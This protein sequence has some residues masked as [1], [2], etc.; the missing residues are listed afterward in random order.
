MVSEERIMNMRI[1]LRII[2]I[3]YRRRWHR[4]IISS[5]IRH[6]NN[7]LFTNSSNS[8]SNNNNSIN[9]KLSNSLSRLLLP[10][11]VES[12]REMRAIERLLLT[13]AI[14]AIKALRILRF[15]LLYPLSTRWNRPLISEDNRAGRV[16]LML[17]HA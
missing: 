2:I 15:F 10:I 17:K 16:V 12:E 9:N 8:S 11:T 7:S 14:L 1:L 5:N 4:I 6:I 13:L 3:N